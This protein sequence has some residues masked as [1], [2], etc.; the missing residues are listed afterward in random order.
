MADYIVPVVGPSRV[1]SGW[2]APRSYPWAND[3]LQLHEGIDI[4]SELPQNVPVPV[5]AAAT[6]TVVR[7]DYDARGYGNYIIV[8]HPN[9]R[10]TLYGHLSNALVRAGQS[11]TQGSQIGIM[12]STG[13]SSGRHLHFSEIVPGLQ[14][15]Y[16]YRGAVNP[17]PNID[18]ARRLSA[19][20]AVTNVTG[21]QVRT[22]V[23]ADI[24]NLVRRYFPA[25]QVNNALAVMSGESGYNPRAW[26]QNGEDSRGLFQ[27]NV[28]PGAHTQWRNVDLFDPET[29]V[30]LAAELFRA[31]GWRPWSAARNLGLWANPN[32]QVSTDYTGAAT[33]TF[34]GHTNAPAYEAAQRRAA[35]QITKPTV[36]LKPVVR[37]G[38]SQD[39]DGEPPTFD[40]I[41]DIA[42]AGTGMGRV[43]QAAQDGVIG[44][45]IEQAGQTLTDIQALS[46]YVQTPE[47]QA[48][49]QRVIVL[50]VVVMVGIL[51]MFVSAKEIVDE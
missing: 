16:V 10:Q 28:G 39:D 31:Q 27:I 48:D 15:N 21:T 1:T 42:L 45:T 50:A 38:T 40:E 22:N 26:N 41:L 6:G 14:N 25:N 43:A 49:V 20:T 5:V 47:F 4:G 19:P 23:N 9:G 18:F 34:A 2:N 8:Q 17:T 13:N 11:V 3:R 44:D 33:Q 35:P 12:G 36:H 37:G 29:N 32:G 51:L 30:R 46:D 24:V 7:V